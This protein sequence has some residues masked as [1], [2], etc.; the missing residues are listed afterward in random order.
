MITVRCMVDV[1]QL[2]FLNIIEQS[3]EHH[4]AQ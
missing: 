3:D 4:H 2:W 1:N